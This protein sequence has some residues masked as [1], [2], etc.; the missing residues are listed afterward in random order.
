[1]YQGFNIRTPR[2]SQ[3]REV[4]AI[5]RDA[6][7]IMLMLAVIVVGGK[8]ATAVRDATDPAGQITKVQTG[9]DPCLVPDPSDMDA[10]LG[11]D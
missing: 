9:V 8:V 6:L 2:L 5:V 3:V 1:M 11:G 10:C 4:F 7:I